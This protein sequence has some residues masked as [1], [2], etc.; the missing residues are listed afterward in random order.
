MFLRNKLFQE[1]HMSEGDTVTEYVT[2]LRD[3]V[4]Q[5]SSLGEEIDA[6]TLISTML[7]NVAPSY[8][9]FVTVLSLFTTSLG[10]ENQEEAVDE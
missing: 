5:L 10:D 9:T 7:N 4:D 6:R 2:K 3:L 8:G 1:T